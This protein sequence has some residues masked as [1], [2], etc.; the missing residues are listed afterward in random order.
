[1]R[2]TLR[3]GDTVSRIGGDEFVVLL[4]GVASVSDARA[5]AAKLVTALEEPLALS[6]GSASI[7]AS[8]GIALY[9]SDGDE[10][11]T[12]LRRADKAMYRAKSLGRGHV[13]T[14]KAADGH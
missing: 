2:S 9:P 6:S 10:A 12:L 3:G 14:V 11:E 13:E 4:P 5:V 7:S 8:I 1:M